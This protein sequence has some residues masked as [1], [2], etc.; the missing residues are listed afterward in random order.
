MI[1]TNMARP[2]AGLGPLNLSSLALALLA[3]ALSG[4]VGSALAMD[5]SLIGLFPGKGAVLIIDGSPPKSIKPGQRSA[6]GIVLISAE[7]E[8]AVIEVDGKMRTLRI[9]QHHRSD[10]NT[11]SGNTVSLAADQRG[12]FIAA[13]TINDSGQ[14]SMLVDTGAS[15]VA[16]PEADAKRMGLD[17]KKGAT[18][19]LNTANGVTQAWR[20]RLDSVR[21]G[22]VSV[23]GIDAVV[24][25]E[26]K[27]PMALL[28]MT[29][30]N[31]FELNR[32]GETMT[33]RKRF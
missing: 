26:G 17:Y 24:I 23:N 4:T 12:H 21:I 18:A 13:G 31:R 30:L 11:A 29:F 33:L 32:Q 5:I 9:G 16:I 1:K 27:L 28:G 20:I 25:P 7:K 10:G 19:S 8:T 2:A 6:E 22:D 15:V 3:L 14:L